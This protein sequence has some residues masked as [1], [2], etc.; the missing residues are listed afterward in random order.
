MIRAIRTAHSGATALVPPTTVSVPS[1][2]TLYPVAGSASPATSGTPRF[3][4]AMDVPSFWMTF[5][6]ACQLG[7]GK[8]LLM[9]PP[10]APPLAPSFH[11]TSL[12][13]DVGVAVSVVPPQPS[14]YGLDAGKST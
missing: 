7:V 8:K 10:L 5:L 13:I 4:R 6:P 2:R 11:T 1:T 3:V 12:V 14:T 9:P